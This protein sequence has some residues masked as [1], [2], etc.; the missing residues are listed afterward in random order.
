MRRMNTNTQSQIGQLLK[1]TIR[2]KA[3]LYKIAKKYIKSY[4]SFNYKF[5]KNGEA[6]LLDLLADLKISTVFDVGANVGE[7]S[8][9]ASKK[10]SNAHIH[11]FELSE[12]TFETL[13]RRH[14]GNKRIL[15]NNFGLSD[16]SGEFSYKDYGLNSG[17]NSLITDSSF[18]EKMVQSELIIGKLQTG[19]QYCQQEGINEIDLLKV[20]VEGAEHLVL[21]GFEEMLHSGKIK[22][23]Q[24]EYGYTNG[25]ARFLIKDFYKLLEACGYI[26][27]P[28]KPNGVIFM[29]FNYALNDFNSGPNF[30]AVNKKYKEIINKLKGTP[31]VGYPSI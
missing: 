7:W 11:T 24:F 28:L 10:F 26:I 12:R 17:A 2:P 31:I 6:K 23:I 30:V 15:L 19:K 9:I 20:D 8:E 1:L 5:E 13:R 21:Q 27:G 22:V 14:Q 4:E 16:M 29:D 3:L 18:H 25:D